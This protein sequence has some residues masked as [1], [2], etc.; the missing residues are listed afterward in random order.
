MRLVRSF[1]TAYHTLRFDK[2]FKNWSE[3]STENLKKKLKT[4][5]HNL[6]YWKLLLNH[7]EL[8]KKNTYQKD[9]PRRYLSNGVSFASFRQA[10]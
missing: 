1:P 7:N 9:A 10:V 8:E 4:E 5:F 3:N 6:V 2:W